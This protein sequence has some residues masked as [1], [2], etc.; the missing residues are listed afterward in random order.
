MSVNLRYPHDGSVPVGG[1]HDRHPVLVLRGRPFGVANAPSSLA[2]SWRIGC[3]RTTRPLDRELHRPGHDRHLHVGCGPTAGRR[4]TADP[5]KLTTPLLSAL[6]VTVS[7]TV[8]SRARRWVGTRGARGPRSA[9]SGLHPLRVGRDQHPAVQDL[10][11]PTDHHDLDRLPG[12]R[13]PDRIREA[14]QRD[15][16]AGVDPPGHPAPATAPRSTGPRGRDRCLADLDRDD[17]S[18]RPARTAPPAAGHR[19]TGAA[20]RCCTPPPSASNAA[21]S[22]R[23]GGELALV[24][25]EELGPHRLVQPLHLPRRG[26]RVRRGQQVPD[27]VLRADPVEHHRPR[28]QP[29]P[30]R[31]H[32]PVIGQDLLRHPVPGQRRTRASH[33]GRAVA[34]RDHRRADH[35][36]GVVIDP[37]HHLHLGAVGQLAPGPSRP[38]ATAPST[39]PV[40]TAG[41]PPA[42]AGAWSGRS[43]DGAPG[44]DRS[45]TAPARVH[46][47]PQQLMGDPVRTPPRMRLRIASTRA[48]TTADI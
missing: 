12:E 9:W 24:I 30:G 11:Q 13:R 28:T 43:P 25:V 2:R 42:A 23:D 46:P 8:A 45:T 6:R 7:P 37:G 15:H 38:S 39:G 48:S 4:H 32:L 47:L 44:P 36:P 17:R 1:R 27:P 29:E 35:E 18:A 14:G 16:P 40:P 5:A 20:A 41:S 10:H 33:T 26:R 21:C 22:S 34:L 31:E 19:R 3:T